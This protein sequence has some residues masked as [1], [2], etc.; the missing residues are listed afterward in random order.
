MPDGLIMDDNGTLIGIEEIKK[1]A[2][3]EIFVPAGTFG[4]G[5]AYGT[6]VGPGDNLGPGGGYGPGE[7]YDPQRSAA[8]AVAQGERRQNMQVGKISSNIR[9]EAFDGMQKDWTEQGIQ[10]TLSSWRVDMSEMILA[11]KPIPAVLAR[12]IDSNNPTPVTAIVER[13]VYAEE[14]RNILIPAGSRILGTLGGLAPT[15]EASSEA[16]KVNIS[17][18]RLIRPDGSIFV[19]DGLTADAQG[20]GGALGYIDKQLFK[21][22]SMPVLTSVLT[23][24]MAYVMADDSETSGEVQS[25]KQEAANDA[26]QNFLDQMNQLF[27]QIL[28]DK[29]DIQAM[30]YVPAGTRIIVFPQV[31]L[32]IRNVDNDGD[33]S[34]NMQRPNVL[35]DDPARLKDDGTGK[36]TGTGS[37][38]STSGAASNSQVSYETDNSAEAAQA[39][40]PLIASQPPKKTTPKPIVVPPP[41]PSS[42]GSSSRGGSTSGSGTKYNSGSSSSS[43]AADESVPQLF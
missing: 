16:A 41:P 24:A 21:K 3:G 9:K 10:K 43:T 36:G 1:P 27:E 19:F 30:A 5:A 39:A 11:D 14:G 28:Q 2:G 12:S 25:S 38:V 40:T 31:D 13:N 4:Q 34:A 32:W 15:S 23:N 37:G 17:W 18:Q 7:R 42:S 26:R 8:L 22:Y 33:E 29:S 20:R 35:I 6:G